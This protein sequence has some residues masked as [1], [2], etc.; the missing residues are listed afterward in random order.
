MKYSCTHRKSVGRH[1]CMDAKSNGWK[2]GE[3]SESVTQQVFLAVW[4]IVLLF[5]RIC[6]CRTT[7]W[8]RLCLS[9]ALP[10]PSPSNSSVLL[11]PDFVSLLSSPVFPLF[12]ETWTTPHTPC[13]AS[14][15]TA[16]H[17]YYY[18]YVF[19]VVV[20]CLCVVA[21]KDGSIHAWR[22]FVARSWWILSWQSRQTHPS[23]VRINGNAM[24]RIEKRNGSTEFRLMNENSSLCAHWRRRNDD[25]DTNRALIRS[26]PMEI[27]NWAAKWNATK[28]K[29]YINL[30]EC[31]IVFDR[32][33]WL[34][35]WNAVSHVFI[36]RLQSLFQLT[37]EQ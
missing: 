29:I 7:D 36:G 12:T 19:H 8:V 22:F 10:N 33:R 34:H 17:F 11:F 28:A 25:N 13:V 4:R 35:S 23:T 1:K 30:F 3:R 24:W 14:C 21:L 26:I 5:G 32:T 16:I 9:R 2:S 27:T 18:Y 37:F 20:E 15:S 31:W 6:L